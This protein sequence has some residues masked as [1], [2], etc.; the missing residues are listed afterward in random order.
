MMNCFL[1]KLFLEKMIMKN[2]STQIQ[3]FNKQHLMITLKETTERY[4]LG[5]NKMFKMLI[6]AMELLIL[7]TDLCL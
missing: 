1:I 5:Q 4:Y 2:L 6:K 7:V 3:H